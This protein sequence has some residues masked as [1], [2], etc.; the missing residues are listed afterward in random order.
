MDF[1]K[2][3]RVVTNEDATEF[4]R[5]DTILWGYSPKERSIY[6]EVGEKATVLDVMEH[7][8]HIHVRFDDGSEDYVDAY[9]F[10]LVYRPINDPSRYEKTLFD[11]LPE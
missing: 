1:Q 9:I 8:G 2:G 7:L 6:F 4:Q 3:D 11:G 5:M 10:D